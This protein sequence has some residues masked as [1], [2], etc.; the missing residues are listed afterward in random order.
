MST[1]ADRAPPKRSELLSYK[2]TGRIIEIDGIETEFRLMQGALGA[3]LTPEAA[4]SVALVSGTHLLKAVTPRAEKGQAVLRIAS[5]DNPVP[6]DLH[7]SVDAKSIP[8]AKVIFRPLEIR[9]YTP[10]SVAGA[11]LEGGGAAERILDAFATVFGQDC[12]EALRAA[13][14]AGPPEITT[15]PLG[16]FPIVFA[17]T[18]GGGDLQVTPVSPI[19]TFMGFKA[20][21]SP[22]F[23]KQKAGEP[24]VPRGKFT[25]QSV[26][27]QMQNISGRIGGN[28]QRFLASMPD[29]VSR[30]AAQ[31]NRFA[32]G[33]RFPRWDAPGLDAWI[34]H[35][36]KLA[37]SREKVRTEEIR[38]A[39][40]RIARR[41]VEDA[42]AWI[43]DILEE[44]RALAEEQGITA[45][46]GPVPGPVAVLLDRP[47][48]ESDR[49][50]I[51]RALNGEHFT[52]I[53][54][55]IIARRKTQ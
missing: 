28:R 50:K 43:D 31:L 41:L 51:R 7:P 37:G 25:N 48:S 47:W 3:P 26:S 38:I 6:A 19:S 21:T 49:P 1:E 45:P 4:E 53:R 33:G 35:Y 9:G 34:R 17:P 13:L 55:D 5:P 32:R 11:I 22:Y 14:E 54:T 29:P 12:L 27:S 30:S 52:A 23:E 44:A 46:H 2:P 36:A 16:E 24:A 18:P 42:L 15:L 10:M 8:L 39:M 40:D 20:M